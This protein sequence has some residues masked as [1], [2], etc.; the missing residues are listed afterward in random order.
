[1][2]STVNP[3][4]NDYDGSALLAIIL[5][6]VLDSVSIS[7]PGA[8]CICVGGQIRLVGLRRVAFPSALASFLCGLEVLLVQVFTLKEEKFSGSLCSFGNV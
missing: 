7:F 6:C 5:E 4:F 2:L 1:M 8:S 3:P